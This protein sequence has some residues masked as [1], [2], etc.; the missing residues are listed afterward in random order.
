MGSTEVD[1]TIHPRAHTRNRP[2]LGTHHDHDRGIIRCTHD[3]R[4]QRERRNL[5][6]SS[7]PAPCSVSVSQSQHALACPKDFFVSPI[8]T[9]ARVARIFDLALIF[10]SPCLPARTRAPPCLAPSLSCRGESA[11]P[12][13]RESPMSFHSSGALLSHPLDGFL[14]AFTTGR[15]G[16]RGGKIGHGKFR[17]GQLHQAP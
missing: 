17:P 9:D 14:A 16:E 11:A 10:D 7:L 1:K 3:T 8:I 15:D 5:I 4:R 12:V 6:L 2:V 13:A